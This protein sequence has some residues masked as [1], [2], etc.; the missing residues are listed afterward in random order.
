M[1]CGAPS[2]ARA[3]CRPSGAVGTAAP[4][5]LLGGLLVGAAGLAL[6]DRDL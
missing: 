5:V 3:G 4:F 6:R 1:P 2:T